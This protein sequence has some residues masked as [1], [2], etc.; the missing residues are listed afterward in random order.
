METYDS[1]GLSP[2]AQLFP[3]CDLDRRNGRSCNFTLQFDGGSLAYVDV[4]DFRIEGA[5]SFS[6]WVLKNLEIGREY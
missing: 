2:T 6:A 3:W 5:V 4:G 1:T